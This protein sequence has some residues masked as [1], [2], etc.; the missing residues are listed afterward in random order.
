MAD[1]V[2]QAAVVTAPKPGRQWRFALPDDSEVF[3]TPP[4]WLGHWISLECAADAEVVFGD[5]PAIEVDRTSNNSAT[6]AGTP[7]SPNVVA[8]ED[9]IGL[10]LKADRPDQFWVDRTDKYFAAE[11]ASDGALLVVRI[12]G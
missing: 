4:A 3:V 5:N 2:T 9:D 8:G 11:A 6:G 7:A 12:T 1:R 10:P